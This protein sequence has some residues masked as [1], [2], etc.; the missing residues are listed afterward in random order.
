MA[1]QLKAIV[2]QVG[3]QSEQ[4]SKGAKKVKQDTDEMKSR[5]QELGK[6]GNA[7]KKVMNFFTGGA[8]WGLPIVGA[9]TA[10]V[11]GY[12]LLK[13]KE[14]EFREEIKK[15]NEELM[16]RIEAERKAREENDKAV[17]K[18][19][20]DTRDMV[21]ASNPFADVV[22]G[23][24]HDVEQSQ[25]SG[26]NKDR[27][28]EFYE[29]EQSLSDLKDKYRESI[30][31]LNLEDIQDQIDAT[32]VANQKLR[33][34]LYNQL[35][36]AHKIEV[37]LKMSYQQAEYALEVKHQQ[38]LNDI[39]YK[40][41]TDGIKAGIEAAKKG[42]DDSQRD[43]IAKLKD[44]KKDLEKTLDDSQKFVDYKKTD[45]PG[46]FGTPTLQQFTAPTI[47]NPIVAKV[48]EVVRQLQEANMKLDKLGV[49]TD[50]DDG[51]KLSLK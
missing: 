34:A 6:E 2:T 16:K 48:G 41:V 43:E 27:N 51:I 24:R 14:K 35:N 20:R 17:N 8:S 33:Q 40:Y 49:H 12:K 26:I 7:L 31:K 15:S 47:S 30:K 23:A 46:Y 37:N 21:N 42:I 22:G 45:T 36:E 3:I 50:K 32:P 13:D 5:W 25:L 44:K 10:V 29:F 1:K 9:I 38:K 11:A 19:R 4:F 18:A 39:K 28:Q